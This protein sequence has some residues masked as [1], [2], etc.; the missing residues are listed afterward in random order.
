MLINTNSIMAMH[1]R[2][3]DI[4]YHGLSRFAI[5]RVIHF[6]LTAPAARLLIISTKDH[7]LYRLQVP[8]LVCETNHQIEFG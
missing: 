7:S 8:C 6:M 2:L 3:W 5:S 4:R 1:A